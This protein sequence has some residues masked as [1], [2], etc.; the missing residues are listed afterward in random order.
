MM[1]G[2]TKND[3]KRGVH[4]VTRDNEESRDDMTSQFEHLSFATMSL[5]PNE[6]DNRDEVFAKLDIRFSNKDR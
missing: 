6:R 3:G 4:A 5:L 1:A 2:H